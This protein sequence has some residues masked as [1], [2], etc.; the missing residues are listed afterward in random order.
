MPAEAHAPNG[1]FTNHKPAPG[2]RNCHGIRRSLGLLS[3]A[4]TTNADAIVQAAP[5]SRAA[6][7]PAHAPLRA[8]GLSNHAQ[9]SGVTQSTRGPSGLNA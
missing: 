3:S 8:N 7:R 2:S 1:K 6:S 9:P 5:S 4:L